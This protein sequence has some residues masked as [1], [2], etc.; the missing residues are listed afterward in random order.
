MLKLEG[1][2]TMKL[3]Q[4]AMLTQEYMHHLYGMIN[5]KNGMYKMA[6]KASQV[7]MVHGKFN[8]LI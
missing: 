2:E 6:L 8:Y 1:S 3:F 7:Q 5:M 4:K